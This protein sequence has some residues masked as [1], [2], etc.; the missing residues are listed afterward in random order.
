MQTA[1][2]KIWARFAVSI[3]LVI[4]IALQAPPI[5]HIILFPTKIMGL[6]HLIDVFFCF[7]LFSFLCVFPFFFFNELITYKTLYVFCI[8]MKCTILL[9]NNKEYVHMKESLISLFIACVE[10]DNNRGS[11]SCTRSSYRDYQQNWPQPKFS[12]LK[13]PRN[14]YTML[15]SHWSQHTSS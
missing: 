9:N 6:E 14:P 4:T 15:F 1:L 2:C 5:F 12:T 13:L 8:I 11:S 10:Q 7:L 3:S